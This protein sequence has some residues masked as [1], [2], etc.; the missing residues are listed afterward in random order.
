MYNDPAT[1]LDI[2]GIR[3]E[4]AVPLQLT[5]FH[6]NLAATDWHKP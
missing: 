4:G 2:N 6:L 1:H 3:S 5:G